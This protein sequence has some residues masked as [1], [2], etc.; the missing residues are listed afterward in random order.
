MFAARGDFDLPDD[1]RLIEAA[2]PIREV[3]LDSVHEKNV[4][5]G[6][7]ST[8]HIWPARRPLAAS[9][10]ALLTT[11]LRDPGSAEARRKLLRDMAGH[12]VEVADSNGV[13]HEKTQGGIFRWGS[14]SDPKLEEFRKQI[15]ASFGGR[16]PRVLDPFAGGGAIPLEA[17]RLGCEVVAS[18]LNPV[19]WFILRCTLHYPRLVREERRLPEFALKDLGFVI[20]FLKAKGIVNKK[21]LNKALVDLGHSKTGYTQIPISSVTQASE[22][23]NADFAWHLRAWAKYVL[24]V[25]R[26]DLASRYPTYAEF[27]PLRKKGRRKSS[28]SS[29]LPTKKT[30]PRAPRLLEPD[31][32]GNVSV[33]DLNAEFDSDYLKN[34]ANPRWVAK[35]P[36]AYLWARTAECGNCRAEIPLLKT[37]WLCKIGKK[38]VLLEIVPREDGSGVEFELRRN[39]PQGEG[40][41]A[42]RREHD[43]KLDSGTM[44]RSGAACPCCG[45]I[46]TMRDLRARGRSRLIGQRLVAVVVNGQAGKEYRLPTVHEIDASNVDYSDLE[47]IYQDIHSGLPTEPL[48]S[49]E[50]LGFRAPLYGLDQWVKIFTNRQLLVLG[51]FVREI[52]QA[53]SA[54]VDYPAPW[55][56]ALAAYLAPAVGRLADRGSTLATWTN[57]RDTI[58]STFARFALPMVWDFAE[59]APLADTTGGFIQAIEWI[60]R[61]YEHLQA[62]EFD[63]SK[64]NIL[65]KS[66]TEKL[67]QRFD[68]ICTDP[69]Y[70]DA[71]PYSDLMDFFYV[72]LRRTLHGLSA[73]TDVTFQERLGPKWNEAEKDGE[74]IDDAS[75]FGGDRV[76]SKKGYED[77]MARAFACFRAAL[78]DDGRLVIVFANK[79]PAAWE[80]LV[81]ALIR[82]GFVVTGSW[83]IQTEMQNR[84][85]SL[86]SAALS[87]SI[88]L[89]C[90]KRPLTA[91]KGW[92]GSVLAEM[93]RNIDSRTHEFWDAGIR[94]PDFIWAA[95]GPAL[96]AF[97]RHAVVQKANAPGERLT[98][99]EFLRRV[100][101]MVVTFLVKQL[102]SGDNIDDELDDLT[103]YYLLHRQGFGLGS[104]PSGACILYALSC[105]LSDS[106]LIGRSDLLIRT[107]QAAASVDDDGDDLETEKSGPSG[108]LRL[109]PWNKRQGRELGERAADGG[110]PPLIDC[111]HRLMQLW[112]AGEQNAVDSYLAQHGLW[113]REIFA[114]IL[115]AV[116]ELAERRSEERATLERIQNHIQ[117]RKRVFGPM[118]QSLF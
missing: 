101:R 62:V 27:E 78:Q 15:R 38:R 52:R 85:R 73:E 47:D 7:I 99:S 66:A 42:Q 100:R 18:D 20:K 46:S 1:T 64:A 82:A 33:A 16:A 5:H 77:G 23:A 87:S 68:L 19:A 115:Q 84:Q 8:L 51:T 88:W 83:P 90:R 105:N 106:I 111:A 69:P 59:S 118:P 32:N 40:N 70:Y 12:V 4:R 24:D 57:D 17:K 53:N 41:A 81:S 89:V 54:M 92:D 58:R 72:W 34:D 14:E 108:E 116:I 63:Q 75:R 86:T 112:Q 21:D 109:K 61:V 97:S 6:H 11:L 74:L 71:I 113:D 45:A 10:A 35:P 36:V 31:E 28:A 25:V 67:N 49:P 65:H 114:R 48:A 56:E 98:V 9:R 39:V 94:G 55:R 93:R 96:E 76:A 3:S 26:R 110:P 29:A 80:T 117:G 91:T 37:G 60:A 13:T 30:E 107:R 102:L 103:T 79:Q 22:P 44:S 104:A 2:F 43:R 50:A 95:T